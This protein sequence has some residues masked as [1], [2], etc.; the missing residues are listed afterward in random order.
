MPC[1]QAFVYVCNRYAGLL[2]ETNEARIYRS[3]F[4]TH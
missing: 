3:D 2:E 4:G 1:R